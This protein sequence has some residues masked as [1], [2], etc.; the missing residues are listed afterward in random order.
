MRI[1]GK[2]YLDEVINVWNKMLD[3]FNENEDIIKNFL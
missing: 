3:T 2:V 1:S